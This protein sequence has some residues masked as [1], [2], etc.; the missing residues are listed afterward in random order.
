MLLGPKAS[1]LQC[2]PEQAPILNQ[3]SSFWLGPVQLLGLI[4]VEGASLATLGWFNLRG[5]CLGDSHFLGCSCG[6]Q[7]KPLDLGRLRPL[8]M[9]TV[10]SVSPEL[11]CCAVNAKKSVVLLGWFEGVGGEESVSLLAQGR[12]FMLVQVENN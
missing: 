4:P 10:F 5:H 1:H 8:H 9:L 2:V 11:C 6:R 12:V 3:T 7:S